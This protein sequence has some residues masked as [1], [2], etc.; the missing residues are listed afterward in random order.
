MLMCLESVPCLLAGVG[1]NILGLPSS[2]LGCDDG[3]SVASAIVSDLRLSIRV[4]KEKHEEKGEMSN[5]LLLK[6]KMRYN[7]LATYSG[8]LNRQASPAGT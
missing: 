6:V 7:G 4:C 8:W 2:L 5:M 1:L 3:G